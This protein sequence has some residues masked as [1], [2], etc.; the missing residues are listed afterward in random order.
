ML[1]HMPKE[2]QLSIAEQLVQRFPTHAPAWELHAQSVEDPAARL[3]VIERGLGARPDPETRGS[4]LIQKAMAL[5]FL[6]ERE[7]ALEILEPMT[8]SIG[9]SLSAQSK[10]FLVLATIRSGTRQSAG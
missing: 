8:A 1:E 10:A 5:H 9:D 2:Q 6:G 4:L 7:Q 3:E